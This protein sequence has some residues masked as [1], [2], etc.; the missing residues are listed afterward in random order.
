MPA[1][2]VARPHAGSSA[3][4]DAGDRAW[5]LRADDDELRAALAA[6][7]GQEDDQRF[8]LCERIGDSE[9]IGSAEIDVEEGEIGL[10]LFEKRE[11]GLRRIRRS[12]HFALYKK[13]WSVE[14]L[15]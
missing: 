13:R 2:P 9:D 7:G 14:L 12:E 15:N 5:P 10:E 11:R 8:A 3:T 4:A 6:Y 1:T